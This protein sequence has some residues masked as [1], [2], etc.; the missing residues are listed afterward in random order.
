MIFCFADLRMK[1]LLCL[2]VLVSSSLLVQARSSGAPGGACDN[3]TPS[4]SGHGSVI[5]T[6][7]VPYNV[8]PSPF[9]VNTSYLQYYPGMTYTC[10]LRATYCKL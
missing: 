4:A 7:T 9:L 10:E 6:T 1:A 2:V 3:L 5:Q 8:D